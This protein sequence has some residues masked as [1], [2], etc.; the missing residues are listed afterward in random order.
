MLALAVQL[1]DLPR[2]VIRGGQGRLSKRQTKRVT[3]HLLVRDAQ[4]V[5]VGNRVEI[6]SNFA[7]FLIHCDTACAQS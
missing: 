4:I 2:I 6:G 7:Q 1:Q 5:S 3:A